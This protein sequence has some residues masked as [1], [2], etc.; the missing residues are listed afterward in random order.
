MRLHPRDARLRLVDEVELFN[1][2]TACEISGENWGMFLD[3]ARFIESFERTDRQDRGSIHAERAWHKVY[4]R[5]AV[6]RAHGHLVRAPQ[7]T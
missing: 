3:Q 6:L 2:Q 7:P 5:D 1:Q 4:D